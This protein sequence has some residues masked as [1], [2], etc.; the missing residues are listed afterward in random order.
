M[1]L[2]T[3]LV[4]H[5]VK[6]MVISWEWV[7]PMLYNFSGYAAILFPMFLFVWLIRRNHLRYFQSS[8]LV[9]LLCYGRGQDE[10]IQVKDRVLEL[11][12]SDEVEE[13][14]PRASG[15][16][17][18]RNRVFL[19][20]GLFVG[21]MASFLWY[22]VLQEKIMVTKY[23]NSWHHGSNMT[24]MDFTN[25]QFIVFS[26]RII[27]IILPVMVL[28]LYQYVRP[29]SK[30]VQ[31]FRAPYY[32]VGIVASLSLV[33]SWCQQEALKYIDF[34]TKILSKSF[35]MVP[36]MLIGHIFMKFVYK[37]SDYIVII[38]I[39]VGAALFMI[40]YAEH[41]TEHAHELIQN[42][43]IWDG[44]VILSIFVVFDSVNNNYRGTVFRK[45]RP[46]T[47]ETMAVENMFVILLSFTSLVSSRTLLPTL[48]QV[49]S[50]REL[51]TD[52]SVMSLT[53]ALG[54]TCEY[55]I[56]SNFGP[57]VTV[58]LVTIRE[59]LS[60]FLSSV[61]FG[62]VLTPLSYFGIFVIFGAVVGHAFFKFAQKQILD[63]K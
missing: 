34:P 37:A 56:M 52:I 6:P 23:Q 44:L 17:L 18:T 14:K 21:K 49:F 25:S 51:F 9:K 16:P 29:S 55:F 60:I 40:E 1:T 47:F 30:Q 2:K 5:K 27:G 19:L 31:L 22:G 39:S 50:S 13:V 24:E 42:Y 26:D 7:S 35:K 46:S 61:L 48:K 10:S 62:H 38:A 59:I 57:L 33:A 63:S 32:K 3:P 11:R 58:V 4:D 43:N 12:S 20:L 53:N 28:V 36:V 8:T 15:R 54:Q 45:H 41:N